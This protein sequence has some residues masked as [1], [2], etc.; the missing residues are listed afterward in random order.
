MCPR[1]G[2][3]CRRGYAGQAVASQHLPIAFPLSLWAR[4]TSRDRVGERLVRGK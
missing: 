4:V 2:T 1:R 3:C